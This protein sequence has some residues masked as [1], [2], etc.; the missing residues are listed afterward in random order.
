MHSATPRSI[1]LCILTPRSS[2]LLLIFTPLADPAQRRAL[3][4]HGCLSFADPARA[5]HVLAAMAFF[6]AQ[7]RRPATL[8]DANPSRPPLALR[9]GAYNEAD[10]LELLRE[11][12]IPTVRVLRATSRDSAIRHACA[13]GF[14]VAMK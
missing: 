14:P 11:H 4:A 3:E 12:G 2:D 5:I 10:A 1:L 7:L 6:S 13:L 8:P 9:R